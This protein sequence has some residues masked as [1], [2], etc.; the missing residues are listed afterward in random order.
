MRDWN[1]K[2][3]L[4]C[5]CK[6]ML[7]WG[8]PWISCVTVNNLNPMIQY[9][10]VGYLILL[11]RGSISFN[12]HEWMSNRKSDTIQYMYPSR[13]SM[14]GEYNK[15]GKFV[16]KVNDR[17]DIVLH[18]F[19]TRHYKGKV[20]FMSR[21]FVHTEGRLPSFQSWA[22]YCVFFYVCLLSFF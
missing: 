10:W 14:Y 9:F 17:R 4:Q 19:F 15:H 1:N 16:L 2:M 8:M 11:L 3:I 20:H 21:L 12:S 7:L 5:I 13:V 22:S 18:F 6:C